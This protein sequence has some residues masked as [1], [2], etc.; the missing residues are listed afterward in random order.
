MFGAIND[1]LYSIDK[2]TGLASQLNADVLDTGY[3]SVSGLAFSPAMSPVPEPSTYGLAGVG[4]LMMVGYVRR[5]RQTKI[6]TAVA[7]IDWMGQ[8]GG[9]GRR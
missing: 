2:T 8:G 4:M 6:A 5:K 7:T 3:A 1:R 9:G